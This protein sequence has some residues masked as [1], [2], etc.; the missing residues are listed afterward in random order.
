M[1]RQRRARR[2]GA[3]LL[4]TSVACVL[5]TLLVYIVAMSWCGFVRGARLIVA[6]AELVREADVAVRR[7]CESLRDG[8]LPV[9]DA[10]G[11]L[12]AIGTDR[13]R[14]D[15]FVLEIGEEPAFE[16]LAWHVASADVG[17]IPTPPSAPRWIRLTMRLPDE[18]EDRNRTLM[19]ERHV[20]LVIVP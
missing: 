11:H 1:R 2:R 9:P 6:R 16:P 7:L 17:P 5:G 20:D 13:F 10:N 18:Y 15:N 3:T 4:E 19:L 12:Q 14:V 8:D